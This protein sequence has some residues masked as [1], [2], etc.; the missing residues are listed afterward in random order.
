MQRRLQGVQQV[1]ESRIHRYAD[2]QTVWEGNEDEKEKA[3]VDQ[4]TC[5]NTSTEGR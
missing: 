2:V 5:R 4:S 3:V 1:R